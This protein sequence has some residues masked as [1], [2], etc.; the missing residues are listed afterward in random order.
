LWA[1]KDNPNLWR[2]LLEVGGETYIINT[3]RPQKLSDFFY[4]HF[5]GKR[6]DE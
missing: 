5:G 1:T 6:V 2:D 3:D 4:N